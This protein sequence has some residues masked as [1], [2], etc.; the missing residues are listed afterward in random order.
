[1]SESLRLLL[2]EDDAKIGVALAAALEREGFAAT[3]ARDGRQGLALASREAWEV[4]VLDWMLPRQS[5]LDILRAVRAAGLLTPVLLLTARDAVAD[6]VEGLEAG[7]DDYLTKPFALAELIARLRALLRRSAPV[8]PLRRQLA[9]LIVD[10]QTRTAT[11]AGQ[12]MELT[13]REF[14]LLAYFIC[15][16]GQIVSREQLERDVWRETQRLT[17][18]DN[19]IDVHMARLRRKLDAHGS[20]RLLQTVRG[21]GYVLK[22]GGS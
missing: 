8:E 14:D 21:V 9:D 13:P 10:F 6:R 22:E 7:A 16:A 11:R 15:R 3:L 4:I 12:R 1:M 17:P 5:G 2:V 18:L 20:A 19:V